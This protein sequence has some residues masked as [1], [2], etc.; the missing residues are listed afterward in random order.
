[1]DLEIATL[2]D[3]SAELDRRDVTFFLVAK[4]NRNIDCAATLAYSQPI[5]ATMLLLETSW[6][7]LRQL[8]DAT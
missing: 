1:M 5:P 7:F 6:H 2:E 4:E 3:I 8:E